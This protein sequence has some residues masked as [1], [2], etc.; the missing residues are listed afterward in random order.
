MS[1]FKKKKTRAQV[2][3]LSFG[4]IFSKSDVPTHAQLRGNVLPR[5]NSS[6]HLKDTSCDSV[7]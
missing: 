5:L 6:L 1:W 3:L 4:L 2:S 7:T